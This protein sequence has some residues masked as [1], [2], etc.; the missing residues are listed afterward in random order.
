MVVNIYLQ[1]DESM[2]IINSVKMFLLFFVVVVVVYFVS[3]FL[4]FFVSLLFCF[5]L[6]RF[7]FSSKRA[8]RRAFLRPQEDL[9]R[10]EERFHR[11]I[12]LLLVLIMKAFL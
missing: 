10:V 3:L 6:F 4:C 12:A 9:K 7:V 5:V 11:G 2:M 8:S 1:N